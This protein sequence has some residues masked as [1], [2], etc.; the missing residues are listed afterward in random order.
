MAIEYAVVQYTGLKA[1]VTAY[2]VQGAKVKIGVGREQIALGK[3]QYDQ[4]KRKAPADLFP[5]PR[6]LWHKQLSHL[7]E[8]VSHVPFVE[9]RAIIALSDADIRTCGRLI[10]HHELSIGLIGQDDY[11]RI[12]KM[13]LGI[14]RPTQE[15]LWQH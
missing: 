11:D 7:D 10:A 13:V 12:Y 3:W 8:L 2:E 14:D 15:E 5:I 1:G 4:I 9:D 6:A